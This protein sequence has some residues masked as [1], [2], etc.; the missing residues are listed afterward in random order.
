MF[1]RLLGIATFEQTRL[2]S[3]SDIERWLVIHIGSAEEAGEPMSRKQL[4]LRAIAPQATVRRRLDRLIATGL[5]REFADKS[6]LRTS[7]LGVTEKALQLFANYE[8]F[9]CTHCRKNGL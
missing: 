3:L 6:D 9:W 8:D 4:Y 1:H 7:R 2:S 5:I